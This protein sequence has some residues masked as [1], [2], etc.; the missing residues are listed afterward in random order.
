MVDFR[1]KPLAYRACETGDW[2]NKLWRMHWEK[3]PFSLSTHMRAIGVV[4]YDYVNDTHK[5]HL[6]HYLHVYCANRFPQS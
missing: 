6:L 5:L 4:M 2:W 1:I 3:V